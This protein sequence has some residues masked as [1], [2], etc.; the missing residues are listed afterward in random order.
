MTCTVTMP[1]NNTSMVTADDLLKADYQ[2]NVP[3]LLDLS[4]DQLRAERMLRLVPGKRMVV[5]ATWRGRP[6]LAK[7]FF[8]RRRALQQADKD[9]QGIQLLVDHKIPTPSLEFAG[10]T[11]DKRVHVLIFERIQNGR[12]LYELWTQRESDEDLLVILHAVMIEL[13]TQ[14]VLGVTQQDMHL[15]NYLIAGKIIYTIDGSD[16]KATNNLLPKAE[17]MNN[18]A[19]L[20]SQLG[21][22]V[23]AL[24][25]S[26][27]LHYARARGWLLKPVDMLEMKFL[28]K[29]HD[30]NRWADYQKKIFR[31]STDFLPYKKLGVHGMLLR[32]ANKSEMQAF[33][34][35]PDSLF[36]HAEKVMLKN[37]RSATVIKVN[38]DGRE[39]VIKRYNM[40][41][42][43]HR[44]RRMLRP[45]RAEH[46][47]R[48]AQKL[49]L[50]HVKT[51]A[52]IAYVESN[53]LGLRGKSYYVMDYV[54]GVDIK[55]Y[56]TPYEAEPYSAATMI[57]R[58]CQLLASLEQLEM[59]HGDLKA[60]NIIVNQALQPLLI[61]LDG[62]NEHLTLTGLRQAW[63][64]EIKRFLCNFVDLP[65]L[66]QIMQ[67]LLVQ[68]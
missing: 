10:S 65:A 19:L 35:N 49:N 1:N 14:H 3:F 53:W 60:T 4:V 31:S 27:F 44:L 17:S 51:A 63:R 61:D 42:A 45:T 16:V 46:C 48:L 39:V 22:G 67:R 68:S 43:W 54:P 66:A 64:A 52:P 34:H 11:A 26:L 18:L 8:D 36:Q 9:A 21:A 25:E 28:I 50:F 40:K 20:L 62:A 12:D 15:G 55:T 24:Q 7:I 37:G 47:W 23:T 30:A 32:S 5:F 38:L 2:F 41:S 58:V 29:Q 59:T 56:L 57:Q 6:V 13:A 33:L